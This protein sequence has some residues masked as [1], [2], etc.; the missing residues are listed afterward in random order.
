MRAIASIGKLI[1]NASLFPSATPKQQPRQ[2]SKSPASV[3]QFPS[4]ADQQRHEPNLWVPTKLHKERQ[5]D[6]HPTN[7]AQ[8]ETTSLMQPQAHMDGHPFAPTLHEW[9][10]VGY[11]VDCGPDWAWET[12]EAAVQRG[13]HKSAMDPE[14][15]ET[16]GDGIAYQVKAGF[17]K[18]YS[19]KEIQRLKPRRLKI[20]PMAVV[21]Q[22]IAGDGSY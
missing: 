10:D 14:N 15:R 19:W 2:R 6:L 11:P 21:P 9:S 8:G 20:S 4:P 7:Q 12:I 16:V 17:C 5:K 1:E 3:Q 13:P 18:I 22:K